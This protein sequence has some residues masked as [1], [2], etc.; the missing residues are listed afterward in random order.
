MRGGALA[1]AV[2][3]VAALGSRPPAAVAAVPGE[4]P[5]PRE[6]LTPAE[7]DGFRST[8]SYDETIAF[9]KRLQT[10]FPEMSLRFY[11]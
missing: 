10:R 2:V 8:P 5:V 7:A 1:V 9:L 6:W 3:A 4:E 11:G